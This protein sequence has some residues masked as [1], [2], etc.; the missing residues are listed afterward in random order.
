MALNS[1]QILPMS[2]YAQK[3]VH[4]FFHVSAITLFAIGLHCVVLSHNGQNAA[5]TFMPNLYSLHSWIGLGAMCLYAQNF[6]LGGAFFAMGWKGAKEYLPSHLSMGL[7]ALCLSC[8]A[9][10]SGI[11]QMKACMYVV[12]SPDTNPA[13][14]Y[15]NDM[16]QGCKLLQGGGV[17]AVVAVVLS[18]YALIPD[19]H[20]EVNS[21]EETLL[22][23]ST[24]SV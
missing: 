13:S 19:K 3:C 7:C 11:S 2:H 17:C 18:F 23:K 22:D 12:D 8:A 15:A 10:V 1:Y 16:S 20:V 6:I 4:V 9:V 24:S 21:I 5:G 14:H